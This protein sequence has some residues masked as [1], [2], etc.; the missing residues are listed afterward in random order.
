MVSKVQ[1]IYLTFCFILLL[2]YTYILTN[3][4][5]FGIFLKVFSKAGTKLIWISFSMFGT[6]CFEKM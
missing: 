1:V 3:F 4:N 2:S 5:N 6:K